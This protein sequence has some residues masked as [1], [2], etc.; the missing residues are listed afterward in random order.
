[1]AS[2]R[3]EKNPFTVSD[4]MFTFPSA[5]IAYVSGEESAH[6]QCQ[7]TD[8]S[9]PPGAHR[10]P[11]TPASPLYAV[12]GH[13]PCHPPGQP[14]LDGANPTGPSPSHPHVL[15]PHQLSLRGLVLLLK[16]NPTDADSSV[17]RE[18]DHLICWLLCTVLHFHSAA[19]H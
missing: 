9:H 7:C 12:P 2:G 18:E 13:L 3:V 14:G 16:R 10:L 1:M 11:R 8:R 15:L 17:L 6:H 19:P 4:K 5:L